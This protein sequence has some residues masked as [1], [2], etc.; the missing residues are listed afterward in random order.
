MTRL[1]VT[2]STGQLGRELVP[3]ARQAGL[4]VGGLART[5]A[6]PCDLT[7]RVAVADRVRSFAPDLV[8]HAGAWTDVDGCER[9]PARALAVNA[10]GTQAVVT[11]AEAVGAHV[12]LLSTDH[13]FAGDGDDPHREGDERNPQS[14]YGRSKRDAEDALGPD[15]AVVRTSWLSGV[16]GH[17]FVQVVLERAVTGQPLRVVDDQI[18]HPTLVADLAPVV[19]QLARDRRSGAYHVTNDGTTSWWGLAREVVEAA[20]LDPEVVVPIRTDELDPPRPAPRPANAVLGDTRLRSVG[21]DPLPDFR[22][23]LRTLVDQLL[24][25]RT[26]PPVA[27]RDGDDLPDSRR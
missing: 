22:R 10:R 1:L 17:G 21:I 23:S 9:D 15:H 13:V 6:H 5:D 18:G 12:V 20:G 11:A 25:T 2:G 7:D 26:A 27:Q 14:W 8:V 19:L 16:H 4:E 24:A 3:L